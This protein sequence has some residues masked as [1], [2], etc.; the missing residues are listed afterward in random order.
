MVEIT[1]FWL[2]GPSAVLVPSGVT[3]DRV[4]PANSP[5]SSAQSPASARET[6]RGS[7]AEG[8]T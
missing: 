7:L 5:G 1:R 2:T 3:G 4:R 6:F 8:S